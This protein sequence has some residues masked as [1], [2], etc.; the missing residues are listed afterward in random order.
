MKLLHQQQLRSE[1]A[2]CLLVT[3]Q[4]FLA[5]ARGRSLRVKQLTTGNPADSVADPP[6][7]PDLAHVSEIDGAVLSLCIENEIVWFLIICEFLW[8]ITLHQRVCM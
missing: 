8:L 3:S 6:F 2:F 1:L 5:T 7:R 4:T